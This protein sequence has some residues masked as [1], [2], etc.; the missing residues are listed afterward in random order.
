MQ[1][2]SITT[3]NYN[4]KQN[5]FKSRQFNFKE[6]I[7]SPEFKTELKEISENKEAKELFAN[8]SLVAGALLSA[9]TVFAH[10][11]PEVKEFA[12][13]C[14]QELDLNKKILYPMVFM[15]LK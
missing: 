15:I 8:L 11:H 10:K 6:Y 14:L 3:T 9:F 5:S 4:I 13:K 1:I 2:Q 7:N 12:N